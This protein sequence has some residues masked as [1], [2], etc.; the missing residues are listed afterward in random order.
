M[1]NRSINT[2]RQFHLVLQTEWLKDNTTHELIAKVL[3]WTVPPRMVL[4]FEGQAKRQGRTATAKEA[5]E[6]EDYDYLLSD[7]AFDLLMYHISRRISLERMCSSGV[8]S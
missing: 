7:N 8:I 5:L 4:P 6:K 2:L 3:G 1:M